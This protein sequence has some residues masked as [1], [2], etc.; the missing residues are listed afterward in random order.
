[1]DI[2]CLQ[3][4][5]TDKSRRAKVCKTHWYTEN[6]QAC[7]LLRLEKINI[8]FLFDRSF[9]LQPLKNLCN[10]SGVVEDRWTTFPEHSKMRELQLRAR[11]RV[12]GVMF[13]DWKEWM[14]TSKWEVSLYNNNS[15][16]S[17]KCLHE[18]N[19]IILIILQK[20]HQMMLSRKKDLVK[21]CG[22]CEGT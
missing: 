14:N 18:S 9:S 20:N 3:I 22:S 1:M 6:F 5:R 10:D 11:S 19:N 17:L 13:I 8:L 16:E 21:A 15:V 2:L 7:P 12:H 4:S